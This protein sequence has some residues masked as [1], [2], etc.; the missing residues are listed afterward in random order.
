MPKYLVSEEG[1]RPVELRAQYEA[2]AATNYVGSVAKGEL[3]TV[4]RVKVREAFKK[5]FGPVFA[6]DVI[7]HGHVCQA[8]KPGLGESELLEKADEG[9]AESR[10]RLNPLAKE[11]GASDDFIRSSTNRELLDFVSERMPKDGS[12]ITV[13]ED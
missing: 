9:A 2:A 13:D 1:K 8:Y 10:D 7:D 11:L 12:S 4:R 6:Y 3:R 5:S